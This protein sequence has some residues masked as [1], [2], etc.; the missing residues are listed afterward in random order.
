MNTV[1]VVIFA[2][3]NFAKMLARPCGGN[4]HDI[5]HISLVKF[6]EFYFSAGKFSR[7][8]HIA[9]NATIIPTQKFACLQ[10]I[11]IYMLKL[12]QF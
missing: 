10:Y 8:Y 9:K 5:S 4:F 6:Y 3:G 12:V 2:G 11:V 7:I 1:N